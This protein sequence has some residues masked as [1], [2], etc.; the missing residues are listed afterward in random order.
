MPKPD[1][2]TVPAF[3]HRYIQQV[4]QDDLL[5]ALNRSTTETTALLGTLSAQQWD[6]AYAPRKWTIKEV[7]QHLIDVERIFCYRAL[8]ISRR[9]KKFLPG[10]DENVYADAS[11]AADRS[12]EKLTEEFL[13]VR[14]GTLLLFESFNETQLA[15]VGTANNSPVSVSAIGFITAGHTAHHLN[16]LRER[17]L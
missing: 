13:A 14:Q 3:Y 8:C 15:A 7:V 6:Y 4:S 10:F 11:K 2:V 9:E 17:Y 1:L 16:I 5:P 12:G